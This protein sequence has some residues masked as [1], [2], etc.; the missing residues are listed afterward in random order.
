[1][2]ASFKEQA[3]GLIDGGADV[4]LVETMIDTLNAKA[5]F[6]WN[7]GTMRRNR[8]QNTNYDFRFNN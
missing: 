8:K 5:S 2:A 7:H 1:M 4:L 6:L 3:R